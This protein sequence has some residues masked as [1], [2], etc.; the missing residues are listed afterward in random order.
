[1]DEIDQMDISYLL[2]L[3]TTQVNLSKTPKKEKKVKI[4]KATQ[5]DFDLL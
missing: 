1:M 3:L 5:A 2:D 4:R